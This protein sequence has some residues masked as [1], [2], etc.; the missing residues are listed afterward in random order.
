MEGLCGAFQF[1]AVAAAEVLRPMQPMLYDAAAEVQ[2]AF[3]VV[4]ES[5]A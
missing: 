3:D 1:D 2:L 5:V 4:V